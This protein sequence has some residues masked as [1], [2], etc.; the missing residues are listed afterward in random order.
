MDA[1]AKI[2]DGPLFRPVTKGG[3]E[4][5]AGA[6]GDEKAV[7][8]LVVRYARE[9]ELGKLAPITSG[10]PAPSYAGAPA[11]ISNLIQLLLG[12]R[13]GPDH[14]TLPGHRA[15]PARGLA[16][17][18]RPSSWGGSW[19]SSP[20][21]SRGLRPGQR[22]PFRASSSSSTVRSRARSSSGK[23]RRVGALSGSAATS[24][25]RF[26]G[27]EGFSPCNLKYMRSLA[28]A[29]PDPEMVPQRV[30]LLPWGHLREGGRHP[31]LVF[32]GSSP[33]R[34]EPGGARPRDPG[35]PSVGGK[36]SR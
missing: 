6:F 22:W 17:W 30:A 36:E 8:R 31:R 32:E 3:G 1:V 13:L 29:R 23:R 20:D 18:I 35:Q 9:T 24:R 10:E 34:L 5:Q 27:S 12:A 2:T 33:G 14:G 25:L 4:V 26:P 11:A 19:R 15:E 21:A 28:E 16:W 7:W